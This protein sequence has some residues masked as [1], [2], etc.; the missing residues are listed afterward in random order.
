MTVGKGG[1]SEGVAGRLRELF[2][3][4]ELLKVRL[5]AGSP[6]DREALIGELAKA[7]G[8]AVAGSVGRTALLYKPNETLPPEERVTLS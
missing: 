8:A 5:P 4:A 6:A 3:R 1:L 2:T 7:G